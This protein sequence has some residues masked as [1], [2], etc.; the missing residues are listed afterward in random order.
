MKLIVLHRVLPTLLASA[1]W[2]ELER[3]GLGGEFIEAVDRVTDSIAESPFRYPVVYRDARRA[4]VERFP[5]GVF[6][7]IR[8]K[9]VYVFSV[10]H[11]H[12]NPSRWQ[13]IIPSRTRR[14]RS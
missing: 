14:R 3:S 11:L 9:V 8:D 1:E 4:Q 13:R 5:F 6:F 12:R 10:S 7:V 2:Y